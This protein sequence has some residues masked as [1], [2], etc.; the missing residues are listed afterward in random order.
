MLLTTDSTDVTD[1][2][3][4]AWNWELSVSPVDSPLLN[5]LGFIVPFCSLASC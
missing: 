5:P 4:K 2:K 3:S 1:G